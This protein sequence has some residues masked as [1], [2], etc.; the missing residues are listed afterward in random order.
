MLG[1]EIRWYDE[2]TITSVSEFLG[3]LP[4]RANE[5]PWGYRGQTEDWPL[6]PALYR[7]LVDPSGKS[8]DEQV[9][10]YKNLESLLLE[11]FKAYSLPHITSSP[12]SDIAWLALAQHHSLP[13]RL[14]DWT[15]SPLV[16]LFFALN[17]RKK[18]NSVVWALLTLNV[19]RETEHT[20]DALDKPFLQ[21]ERQRILDEMDR[22][23]QQYAAVSG[24]PGNSVKD[25]NLQHI[26]DRLSQISHIQLNAPIYRYHP[27]HTTSRITAQQGLFT[28]QTM[29]FDR[30]LP[31]E[32]QFGLSLAGHPGLE[33]IPDGPWFRKYIIPEEYKETIWRELDVLGT[34][35]YAVYPDL[36]GIAK[37]LREDV[38]LQK[39]F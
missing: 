7:R 11:R 28:V 6:Q 21:N 2:Y 24:H 13:T 33:F 4:D 19:I 9:R 20:L 26:E 14:L 25:P 29:S 1:D 5:L 15:E 16:A 18:C 34:N 37:K 31:L 17:E 23:E 10:A 39:R 32:V 22:I 12:N 8:S 35:H 3:E 36:E 38:R 30:L 27:S